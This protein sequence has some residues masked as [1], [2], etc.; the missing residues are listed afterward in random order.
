MNIIF[1]QVLSYQFGLCLICTQFTTS[2]IQ[3]LSNLT[4]AKNNSSK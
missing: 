2:S 1:L 4:M 3:L